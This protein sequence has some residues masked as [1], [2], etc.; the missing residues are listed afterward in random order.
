[1]KKE[2]G[3]YYLGIDAGTNSVGVALTTPDYSLCKVN[4]KDLWTVR[5]FKE[6]ETAE[7]RRLHRCSIRRMQRKVQRKKLL[8]ELF[9]EEISKVDMGFYLRLNESRYWQDDKTV[10]Q[11]YT[12][13]CDADY[14]DSNFHAQ[15]PTIYHL[16]KDLMDNSET[17]DVRLVFLAINHIIKN[18]GH[19]L[20]DGQSLK[21][22]TSLKSV[23]DKLND[24]LSESDNEKFEVTSDSLKSIENI[25]K[26]K[27]D[28]KD[29]NAKLAKHLPS[30]SKQKKAILKLISGG[31]DKLANLYDDEDLKKCEIKSLKFSDGNFDEIRDEL[32]GILNERFY[33]IEL[34]KAIYD[35]SLL[36]EVLDG[37][38]YISYAKTKVF[39]N[40]K[41]DLILLKKMVKKYVPESYYNIFSNPT[42]QGNYCSYVGKS[43]KNGKKLAI[44]NQCDQK[45]FNM[46]LAKIF[47]NKMKAES[48]LVI[49]KINSVNEAENKKI[50]KKHV[51]KYAL[52]YNEDDKELLEIIKKIENKTLLPKQTTKD[53][54][55]IPSQLNLSELELILKNASVYLSFL[56]KKDSKG[57]TAIDKILS[58]FTFRIPY[59]VGPI[60]DSHKLDD[61]KQCWIEK[62]TNKKIYP[63]NFN[64]VV[65]LEASAEK[66]ITKM[67]N[68]CTYLIGE[69]ILPKNSILYEK[70]MVLNE[71]NNIMVSG[72]KIT[73]EAKQFLFHEL[74]ESKKNIAKINEKKIRECLMR[75]DYIEKDEIIT[76]FDLEIKSR[77]RSRYDFEKI[78][79]NIDSKIE[80]VETIIIWIVLFGENKEILITKIKNSY[81]DILSPTEIDKISKLNYKGWGKLSRKVLT[82]IN[83]IDKA[84]GECINIISNLWNTNQNL[85]Q[86]LSYRFD[87]FKEIEK[88]NNDANG[89]ITELT[90]DRVDELYVSPAVKRAI[91]QTLSVVKDFVKVMHHEPK[92]IFIEMAR[93]PEEKKRTVSRKQSLL[94]LYKN[95]K[96]EE[97]DLYNELSNLD[98]NL[99]KNNQVYLYYTQMGKCMYSGEQINL[100]DIFHTNIYDKDHVFPQSLVKDDSFD[101]LVLVK[102]VINSNRQ[103]KYPLDVD[104]QSRMHQFWKFL[105]E[106]E[107]ISKI[108]YER[109]TRKTPFD[110]DELASFIARQ[111]VE[112]RQST[113]AIANI[114]KQVYS[115]SEVIY[116]KAGN[117]SDFRQTFKLLKVR[118]INDFH[119]AK[120][121]YLNI[122]VGNVYN[123][124]FTSN[125]FAFINQ[126]NRPPYSLKTM[127]NYD[128]K[129]NNEQAWAIGDG[130]T[131]G[132]V[133]KVMSKNNIL[134]TRYAYEEKGTFFSENLVKKSKSQLPIKSS[135]SKL[136]DMSKYG[137]YGKITGSY[138]IF[139]EHYKKNKIVKSVEYVPFYLVGKIGE[140]TEEKLNYCINNL[141]LKNPRILIGKIKIDSLFEIDGFQLHL[142][143]RSK[144]SLNFKVALQ[145]VVSNNDEKYLKKIVKYVDRVA[146]ANLKKKPKNENNADS[147][148][149]VEEVNSENK[150]NKKVAKTILITENDGINKE[151]NE[152]V[153]A[154]FYEKLTTTIYQN[155]YK[156]RGDMLKSKFLDFCELLVEDQCIVL[157]EILHLFQCDRK[158]SDLA[159]IREGRFVGSIQINKDFSSNKSVKIIH[160]SPSGFFKNELDL[161]RL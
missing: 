11:K 95:C 27:I 39:D 154:M 17:H 65:D 114:L 140:S 60:N 128:V 76:G 23:L 56:N 5:L 91:W 30:N 124:K 134:F 142:S 141:G 99:L 90:Y 145:L 77:C 31:S 1:M 155:I 112:T 80:M 156:S 130:G 71:L 58:I 53:N 26:A 40:H 74:F 16:R 44:E 131:I 67:T 132:K 33:L 3:D 106:K 70:F 57:L 117:I 116:T 150:E 10:N 73:V 139:V 147:L 66:F 35:W 45:E 20:F 144:N 133:R 63:W 104:I 54:C 107:F 28:I 100:S 152:L 123:V 82:D 96:D 146:A 121:A 153:Y 111:L 48:N 125:A 68:K 38:K 151:D 94:G 148:D 6:G 9:A 119:H 157:Y 105:L 113:K 102:K 88:F 32:E 36:A 25:L 14:T 108:K 158:T 50:K 85:M 47:N 19:F 161:K 75:K 8:Q 59:Y 13:F 110:N 62:R 98:E 109:L 86:L 34:L 21:N 7:E 143:G 136:S 115:K 103:N 64:E 87:Y 81:K 29:K 78:I 37:E 138:F 43:I 79:E 137:G 15:Y 51:V 92:K 55:I 42:V 89:R 127:Y 52:N 126:K 160:Q 122:V 97:K 22:V 129:N 149:L 83:H 4:G 18:R 12:L 84:T 93:G 120:D 41:K 24:Y 101:N 159:L 135:N 72:E 2:Y 49:E 118:E 61:S 46:F 69:D